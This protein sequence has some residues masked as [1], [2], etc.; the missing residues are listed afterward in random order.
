MLCNFL[1][2]AI[3]EMLV[4]IYIPTKNR[5][6][7]LQRAIKSIKLQ[8]FNSIEIIVVD[9]GSEDGT[10]EYLAQ[11]MKDGNLIAIFHEKSL[12]ACA[13]RNAAIKSSRGE[14]VTGLDDDDYFLSNRRIEYFIERWKSVGP[15]AAGI[16]DSVKV[17]TASGTFE[18]NISNKVS[19]KELRQA[20]LVGSQVFAPRNNY[21]NADLFD[22]EMPAWQDWDLWL[23]MSE[24]YGYFININKSTYLVDEFHDAERITTRNEIGIRT[25]MSRLCWKIKNI[26]FKERASL[27]VSMHAYPQVKPTS[28]EVFILILAFRLKTAL[29]SAKK[30]L[31]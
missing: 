7:L 16:F 26:N 5:L 11:E 18:K 17:K 27:I 9:D 21:L 22:T 2:N 31:A 6:Q 3:E 14:F 28:K 24:K 25:A 29:R 1:L 8:T 4:S 10:R 20:N 30:M 23:R 13:A 19:Y 12:G 15:G